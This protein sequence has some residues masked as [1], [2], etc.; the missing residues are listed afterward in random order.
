MKMK[1]ENH[2]VNISGSDMLGYHENWFRHSPFVWNIITLVNLWNFIQP[3]LPGQSFKL[4]NTSLPDLIPQ[5]PLYSHQYTLYFILLEHHKIKHT[6]T[7]DHM[8]S[9]CWHMSLWWLGGGG[10]PGSPKTLIHTWLSKHLLYGSSVPALLAAIQLKHTD[11]NSESNFVLT[12]SID[13]LW[14]QF[15]NKSHTECHWIK[16]LSTW[17]AASVLLA[18]RG[19]WL[20]FIWSSAASLTTSSQSGS[21]CDHLQWVDWWCFPNSPCI[22]HTQP[23]PTGTQPGLQK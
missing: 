3:P 14:K 10:I 12:Y 22:L 8:K 1:L 6:V 20:V 2:E 16:K 7:N 5:N 15:S 9:L 13:T 17:S 4:S 23:L 21:S 11:Y 18:D 19:V